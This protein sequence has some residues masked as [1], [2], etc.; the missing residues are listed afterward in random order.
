MFIHHDPDEWE[1]VVETRPCSCGGYPGSETCRL[2]GACNGSSS[3]SMKRRDPAEVAKIK[4]DKR[5]KE[6]DEILLQAEAIKRQ[7]VKTGDR[8]V[9]ISKMESR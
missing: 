8:I 4:A 2:P 3:Y 6:E 9:F 7:R 5:R 1:S